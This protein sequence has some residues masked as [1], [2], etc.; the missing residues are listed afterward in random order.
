MAFR[1]NPLQTKSQ[2]NDRL[3]ELEHSN[4]KTHVPGGI[5]E[6][7]SSIVSLS[8]SDCCNN[9][10][11]ERNLGFWNKIWEKKNS[12]AYCCGGGTA[13]VSGTALTFFSAGA[14]STCCAGGAVVGAGAIG[15]ALGIGL[16]STSLGIGIG[17]IAG[18]TIF[19]ANLILRTC[20]K[21]KNE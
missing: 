4:K 12:I 17:L 19:L 18:G 11:P 14:M 21:N 16:G 7:R 6:D 3:N 1:V 9:S 2:I 8:G 10:A 13:V 15:S 5:S 20:R